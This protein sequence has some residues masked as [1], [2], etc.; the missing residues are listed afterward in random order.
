MLLLDTEHA[1][2]TDSGEKYTTDEF[3]Y[4]CLEMFNDCP[5]PGHFSE[6]SAAMQPVSGGRRY[7]DAKLVVKRR[8]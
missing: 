6:R 2:N 7:R 5:N 8:S 4:V 3:P 1:V